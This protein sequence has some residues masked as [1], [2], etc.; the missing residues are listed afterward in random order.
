M[1]LRRRRPSGE[2]VGSASDAELDLDGDIA[3]AANPR[4]PKEAPVPEQLIS[5]IGAVLF[6]LTLENA[7]PPRVRRNSRDGIGLL[8]SAITPGA[9]R[10]DLSSAS[11]P[12]V[13]VGRMAQ[14]LNAQALIIGVAYLARFLDVMLK[15]DSGSVPNM[16]ADQVLI[17]YV[18]AAVLADKFTNVSRC[19]LLCTSAPSSTPSAPSSALSAPSL[20]LRAP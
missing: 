8:T 1:E 4:K 15:S 19:T 9:R 10:R 16:T 20:E 18:T 3:A 12:T 2:S 13:M 11:R 6:A 17:W 5:Q 7:D 14:Y